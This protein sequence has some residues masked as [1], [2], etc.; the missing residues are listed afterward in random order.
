MIHDNGAL[1]ALVDAIA[2]TMAPKTHVLIV[3]FSINPGIADE[4]N[5][6]LLA[7]VL[8]QVQAEREVL[9]VYA[10]VNLAVRLGNE[11]SG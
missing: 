8:S 11:M 10:L 7:L 9:D 1:R 4:V 5:N 3:D 2:K 6:P